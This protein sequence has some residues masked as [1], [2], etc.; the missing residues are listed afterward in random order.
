MLQIFVYFALWAAL[1]RSFPIFTVLY[2]FGPRWRA[3]FYSFSVLSLVVRIGIDHA[4]VLT[5]KH[6]L[7]S[8]AL[9]SSE[10]LTTLPVL[11]VFSGGTRPVYHHVWLAIILLHS[12]FFRFLLSCDKILVI[13]LRWHLAVNSLVLFYTFLIAFLRLFCDYA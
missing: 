4:L 3:W 11:L 1:I 9:S 6:K 2:A 10:L 5:V 12:S 13:L 8:L 7:I